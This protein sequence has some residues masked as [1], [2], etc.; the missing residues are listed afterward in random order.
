[1]T[2]ACLSGTGR[3][4]PF[5]VATYQNSGQLG[6]P[7]REPDVLKRADAQKCSFTRVRAVNT[8]LYTPTSTKHNLR[9]YIY[10]VKKQTK[11]KCEVLRQLT[12]DTRRTNRRSSTPL[13]FSGVSFKISSPRRLSNS[14]L[15]PASSQW[16][17][18]W[19][20]TN[21]KAFCC[22][23]YRKCQEYEVKRDVTRVG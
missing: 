9:V 7:V 6:I 8:W 11:N 23:E 2:T 12:L 14:T 21:W 19:K 5:F 4:T 18:T 17:N 15:R 3:M 1:M 13:V 20:A 22:W 16:M 10:E